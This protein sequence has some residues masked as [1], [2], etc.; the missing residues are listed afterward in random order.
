[1]TDQEPHPDQSDEQGP[2]RGHE[3]GHVPVML[4]E[5]LEALAPAD[6]ETFLDGTFGGGGYTRGLLD[7]A[8]CNVIALDR[9]WDAIERG[10]GMEQEYAGRLKL[11]HGNFGVADTVL[12][13]EGITEVDGIAID[14]GVSSFQLDQG[15]RGFSFMR[16]G[17]LDMRM[18]RLSGDLTASEVVNEFS[19]QQIADI[20][21]KYGEERQSRRIARAIVDART[22]MPIEGTAELA[23]IVARAARSRGASRIHPAT[24]TFQALRIYVNRELDELEAGLMAW[25]SLLRPGG[26]MAVVSF[27]SLEDRIVKIFMRQMSGNLGQ[28]SRHLP[29]V[30]A[31]KAEPVLELIGRKVKKPSHDEARANPRARSARMRVAM[32]TEAA[33]SDTAFDDF[34]EDAS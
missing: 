21:Y 27:H 18:D 14:L 13:A 17:P 29:A 12:R 20:I 3:Q 33:I 31:A 8:D 19:E 24:R 1:M 6:G 30:V 10:R 16:D 11:L 34:R 23:K 5:V 28:G 26:K 7:E 15:E 32:R 25:T 2:E 4:A 22:E 9:D